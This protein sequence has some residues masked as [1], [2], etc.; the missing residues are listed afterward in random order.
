MSIM[1]MVYFLFIVVNSM[2]YWSMTTIQTFL[3]IINRISSIFQ[4][5]EYKSKRNDNVP[6]D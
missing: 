4:L 3:G 6:K 5:E 2:T 1:A